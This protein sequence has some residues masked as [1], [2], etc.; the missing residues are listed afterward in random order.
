MTILDITDIVRKET[1]IYYRREFTGKAV[2]DLPGRHCT[3][4][5]EFTIETEPTGKKD[6]H[7]TL[8]DEIDYPLLSILQKL[9]TFILSLENSDK[10]P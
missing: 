4:K 6:I 1:F 8:I 5:I 9:K 3:G 10:L 2:Y 7:I